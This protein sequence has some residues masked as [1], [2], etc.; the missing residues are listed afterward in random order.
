MNNIRFQ[1]IFAGGL[2][3]GVL[4]LR[5]FIQKP[6]TAEGLGRK[7]REVVDEHSSDHPIK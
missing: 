5:A 2:L 7:V 3:H 1:A 4:S 6:V